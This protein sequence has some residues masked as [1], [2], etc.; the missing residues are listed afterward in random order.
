M[1]KNKYFGK[2][3]EYPLSNEPRTYGVQ[4]RSS[5]LLEE[6]LRDIGEETMEDPVEEI[7]NAHR[8][9]MNDVMEQIAAAS[10]AG[11]Y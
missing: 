11:V 8:A 9:I 4:T 7:L 10:R 1:G 3:E 5:V 2:R 6:A